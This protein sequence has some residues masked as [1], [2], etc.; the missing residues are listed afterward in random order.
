MY[1]PVEK[2]LPSIT[3]TPLIIVEVQIMAITVSWINLQQP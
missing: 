1:I 3:S 2:G